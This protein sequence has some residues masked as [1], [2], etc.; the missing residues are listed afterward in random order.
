MIDPVKLTVLVTTQGIPR[1]DLGLT[2][3]CFQVPREAQSQDSEELCDGI[4]SCIKFTASN[5][6]F[7]FQVCEQWVSLGAPCLQARLSPTLSWV[8]GVGL[9]NCFP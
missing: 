6:Y 4:L 1:L 3:L 7:R 2:G 8:Y 9:D 5:P